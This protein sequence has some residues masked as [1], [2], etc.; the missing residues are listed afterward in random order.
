[1]VAA[2]REALS[3]VGNRVELA[4]GCLDRGQRDAALGALA[5][6][7]DD[8]ADALALQRSIL[9]IARRRAETP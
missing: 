5:G 7:K 2:M 8:L 3:L 6:V 1:M 9:L 4:S